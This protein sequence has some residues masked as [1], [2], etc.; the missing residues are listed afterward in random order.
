MLDG[1]EDARGFAVGIGWEDGLGDAAE[2]GT[3]EL[4]DVLIDAADLAVPGEA[5]DGEADGG[6]GEKEDEGVPEL[7]A[8]ADGVEEGASGGGVAGGG[9]EGGSG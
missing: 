6:E 1:D 7:E 3:L 5:I 4:A 2:E 8:P 9:I